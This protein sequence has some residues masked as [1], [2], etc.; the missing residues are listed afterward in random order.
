M[1]D[2][3]A[4]KESIWCLINSALQYI[5]HKTR[6]ALNAPIEKHRNIL[7]DCNNIFSM[8]TNIKQGGI[9][10][11]KRL[12][13]EINWTF[14][15]LNRCKSNNL[16]INVMFLLCFIKKNLNLYRSWETRIC[17]RE[18]WNIFSSWGFWVFTVIFTAALFVTI[19]MWNIQTIGYLNICLGLSVILLL[20]TLLFTLC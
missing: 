20:S 13:Q 9:L 18:E 7:K 16:H 6:P 1:F 11:T 10:K 19:F 17:Q 14:Y 15:L 8:W 3:E 12:S 4:E 5:W 2:S